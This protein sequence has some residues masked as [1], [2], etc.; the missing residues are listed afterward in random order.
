MLRYLSHYVPHKPLLQMFIT[1]VMY[2]FDTFTKVKS[3]AEKNV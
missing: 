1:Y 2:M 3:D